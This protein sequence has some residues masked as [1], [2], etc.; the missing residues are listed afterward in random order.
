VPTTPP[1]RR[2]PRERKFLGTFFLNVH[3]IFIL[4]DSGALHDFVSTTCAERASLTLVVSRAPY[5]ISRPK[6]RA[7]TD[8]IALKVLLELSRRVVC[9]DLIVLSGQ[10]I[11]VILGMK[12]MKWHKV[13]LDIAT[14][15]VHLYSSVDGE[16]TLHLP[17]TN[18]VKDCLHHVVKRKLEDIQ[19]ICEFLDVFP[20]DLLGMPTK[21]TIE[22]KIEL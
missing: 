20:E 5:V 4:F 3:P 8:R 13:V 10:G 2:Y 21:R 11:D 17:A 22:F 12:W 18:R 15:S 19:V 6:G 1:W 9:T 14:K 16:V 7:D